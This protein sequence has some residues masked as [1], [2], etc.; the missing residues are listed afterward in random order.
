MRMPE[1]ARI[2]RFHRHRISRWGDGAI[3]ALGWRAPASQLTRFD[4]IAQVGDMAGRSVLDLGCGYGDLKAYLDERFTDVTYIGVDQV[5]EFIRHAQA[6]YE[7]REDASFY[8]ADFARDALPTADYVVASGAFAYRRDDPTFYTTMIERMYGV[9]RV[10]VAFN[11]L[12]AAAFSPHSILI[13]QDRDGILAFCRS[14]T[15]RVRMRN[16]YATD[17]FT[18]YMFRS[19]QAAA[20]GSSGT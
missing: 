1:R 11:M 16:D 20:Q 12:D 3:G 8:E 17:D 19:E 7:G 15:P 10:G 2:I 14:I 9:A 4:V 5:P 13:G 18:V 6:R